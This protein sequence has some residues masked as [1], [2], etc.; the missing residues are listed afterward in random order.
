[1]R[2]LQ[3]TSLPPSQSV[4]FLIDDQTAAAMN[5]C[6]LL[7]KQS[8]FTVNGTDFDINIPFH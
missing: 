3:M 8:L 5:L 1:M 7:P 2:L 4:K 6:R